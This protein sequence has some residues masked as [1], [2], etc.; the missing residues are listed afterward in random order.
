MTSKKKLNFEY[1]DPAISI[2]GESKTG[3]SI[4]INVKSSIF[5]Y[6]KAKLIDAMDKNNLIYETTRTDSAFAD[7]K[8]NGDADVE[9]QLEVRYDGN[10]NEQKVKITLYTTTCK[11]CGEG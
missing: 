9:Y 2:E 1:R 6:A 7:S 10:G 3:A 5:E 8:Y 11:I 4:N